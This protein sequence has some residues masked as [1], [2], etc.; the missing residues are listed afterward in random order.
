MRGIATKRDVQSAYAELSAALTVTRDAV[1]AR[2]ETLI[3]WYQAEARKSANAP[4]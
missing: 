1:S 4:R 2:L 3:R